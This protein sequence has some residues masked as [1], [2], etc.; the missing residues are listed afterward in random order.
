M[1]IWVISQD[2][3]KVVMVTDVSIVHQRTASG[4]MWEIVANGGT[5]LGKYPSE[6]D[7]QKALCMLVIEIDKGGMVFYMPD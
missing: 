4:I 1:G 3:E 6:W 5:R 7:A 2:L